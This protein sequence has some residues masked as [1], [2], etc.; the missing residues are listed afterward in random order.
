[1]ALVP[2]HYRNFGKR[3][4]KSPKL[5]FLDSGLLCFL[6]GIRN[7][8][9]LHYHAGR[10]A[11]FDSFVFS[12]VYKNYAHRG[13]QPRIFFWKDSRG[14]EIDFVIEEK[15]GLIGLEAKSGRTIAGDF[16]GA[17]TYWRGLAG[18]ACKGTCLIYGGDQ[19][20]IRQGTAIYPWYYL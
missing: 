16:L 20:G 13:Q 5:Y 19:D 12:E 15:N 14:R 2:P 8:D 17:L 10:G 4:I 3:L 18:E 6:L 1:L 9:E 7:T 11:V